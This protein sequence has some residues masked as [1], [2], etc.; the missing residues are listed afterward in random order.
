MRNYL[1]LNAFFISLGNDIRRGIVQFWLPYGLRRLFR[2]T[3][4]ALLTD[5]NRVTKVTTATKIGQ[6]R[7][8]V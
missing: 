5:P 6:L 3:H 8:D 4:M 7:V 2:D 1:D